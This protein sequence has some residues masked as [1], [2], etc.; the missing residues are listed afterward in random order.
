MIKISFILLALFVSALSQAFE[1]HIAKYQLSINGLKIAEETRTLNHVGQGYFYTATAKTTGLAGFIKN[2]EISASSNFMINN[3]GVAS[4]AYQIIEQEDQEIS[5]SYTININS[6]SGTVSSML[7]KT[8]PNIISW[9]VEPNNITDP[10]SVFLAI[11]FD[12]V[13]NP[14]LFELKYQIADGKSIEQQRFKKTEN[15]PI[16]L[17][18]KAYQAIKVE[19]IDDKNDNI[20]AYFLPKYDHLPVIIKKTKKYRDYLYEMTD[21][22]TLTKPPK[23]HK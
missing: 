7:T 11:S 6:N 3:R 8:Q 15:Q 16:T 4:T 20:Q 10:L 14:D 18:G 13:N 19:R 5:K 9:E 1:P 12:L 23:N 21:F 2:Y 17:D 22:K